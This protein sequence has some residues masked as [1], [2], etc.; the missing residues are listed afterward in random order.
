MTNKKDITK[1]FEYQ[2]KHFN[3]ACT[4]DGQF[5]EVCNAVLEILKEQNDPNRGTYECFHCGR[6]SVVWGNDFSAEEYGYAQSGIVHSLTCNNCG[7]NI[8]YVI[9]EPIN[10]GESDE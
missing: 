3:P 4:S 9:L 1:E 2:I 10:E 5:K 7:A 8:E 6:R